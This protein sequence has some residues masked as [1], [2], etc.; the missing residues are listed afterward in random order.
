MLDEAVDDGG[1][2]GGAY[3]E[4]YAL[5]LAVD[6]G[7]DADDVAVHVDDGAAAVAVVDGGVGLDHVV[8]DAV[9]GVDGAALGADDAEG[10]GGAAFEG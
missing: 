4:A 7:A 1:G 6:G 3:G 5:G 9:L 8:E 10:D 2:D